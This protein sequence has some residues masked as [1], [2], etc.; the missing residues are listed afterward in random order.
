MIKLAY[1]IAYVADVERTISFYEEAFGLQRRFVTP[2]ADYGELITGETTL[3]FA[4]FDM[5][6]ANLPNGYEESSLT[7]KPFAIEIA[8]STDDVEGLF[9]KAI[10]AGATKEAEPEY[11]SHGQWV[12]YVRDINGLLV[13]ICSPMES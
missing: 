7:K 10:A 1:T 13:E 5:A 11:K 12:G 3:S 6:K 2:E 8:F 4:S 9:A